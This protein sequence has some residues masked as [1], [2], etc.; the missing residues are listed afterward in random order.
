MADEAAKA[1]DAINKQQWRAPV[2]GR[3]PKTFDEIRAN[4]GA[5]LPPQPAL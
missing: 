5:G 4:T 1:Q 3:V 2:V